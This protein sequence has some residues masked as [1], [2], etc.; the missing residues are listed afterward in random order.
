MNTQGTKE[1]FSRVP[2]QWDALYSRENPLL[3]LFNRVF[4]PG[5]FQRYEL[6]FSNCGPLA[7]ASVLDIGCG[8]GRYSVEFAERGAARVTGID[9][10]GPM[11]EFSRSAAD[12]FGLGDKIKFIAGDFLNVEFPEP[13]DVVIAMGLFDYLEDPAP[14]FAKIARLTKRVFLASFPVK[15]PLWDVQRAV[16]YRAKQVPIFY[17]SRERLESLYRGAGFQSYKIVPIRHG[18][19]GMG[20]PGLD[21]SPR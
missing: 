6:T 13:F 12:A 3:Y 9:F 5:L 17:Y 14:M 16:R 10:A 21:R 19:F 1:Y 4:R 11:I 7:D 20:E 15:N 8:T 2:K 18:F